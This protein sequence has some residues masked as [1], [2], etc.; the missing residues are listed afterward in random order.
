VRVIVRIRR[1]A[2]TRAAA[3]A[4][5]TSL[6]PFRPWR[7]L[8]ASLAG[9]ALI[10]AAAP[11]VCEFAR[12]Y[13]ADE[14]VYLER[15]TVQPLRLSMPDVLYYEPPERAAARSTAGPAAVRKVELPRLKTSPK[16]TAVILQPRA[17]ATTDLVRAAV[18][19]QLAYW[20]AIRP[21]VSST[22]ER[23][24][25]PGGDEAA[26]APQLQLEAPPA[27]DVSNRETHL[28]EINLASVAA[29]AR[30]TPVQPSA[31]VPVRAP[32]QSG[33]PEQKP[34]IPAP[35]DGD[36]ANLIIFSARKAALDSLLTVP[37]IIQS[38]VVASEGGG[39]AGATGPAR[40]SGEAAP[41]GAQA[42]PRTIRRRYAGNGLFD[43]V[44]MQSSPA[45][46]FPEAAGILTGKPVSMV[47]LEL[48]TPKEWILQYCLPVSGERPRQDTRV[49]SVEAS[50]ALRAPYPLWTVLSEAELLP[51]AAY[52]L[53]HGFLS[54]QGRLEELAPVGEDEVASIRQ[55]I[56]LLEKWEFSPA[57]RDNQ[58][59]SVEILLAIPPTGR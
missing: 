41:Q 22:P 46:A 48:G 6:R 13:L 24:I 25:R 18:L 30:P 29:P 47:Y 2:R 10:F 49:V 8:I 21:R 56:P 3:S 34:D 37:P 35:Q 45:D 39:M 50:P 54:G 31:T 27:L 38:A 51:K 32:G 23:L 55:L 53:I 52:A 20:S 44:V 28:D 4:F 16:T 11:E 43:V 59:V 57:R 9:H 40:E 33:A 36:P 12:L 26:S 14:P 7:G 1:R 19:P 5:Q 15:Y 17:R 58:P 42:P